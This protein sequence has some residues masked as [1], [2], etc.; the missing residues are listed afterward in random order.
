M[1]YMWVFRA[2]T[3]C[4]PGGLGF[5]SPAVRFISCACRFGWVAIPG[6]IPIVVKSCLTIYRKTLFTTEEYLQGSPP[7]CPRGL[8][9]PLRV[10]FDWSGKGDLLPANLGTIVR[11]PEGVECLP[12]GNSSPGVGKDLLH[13][14]LAF[15]QGASKFL[16]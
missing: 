15:F 2:G 11:G 10:A 14:P 6:D 13:P 3:G 7:S 4:F 16:P 1:G 9:S 8:R 5:R 12:P